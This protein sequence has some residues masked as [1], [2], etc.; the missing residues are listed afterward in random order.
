MNEM[1]EKARTEWFRWLPEQNQPM[2]FYEHS[3]CSPKGKNYQAFCKTKYKG[4][5]LFF[6]VSM[7][8]EGV[9]SSCNVDGIISL[10]PTKIRELYEQMNGRCLACGCL[11]KTPQIIDIVDNLDLLI[12]RKK[13]FYIHAISIFSNRKKQ[14]S[15]FAHAFQ[16]ESAN[17]D[18]HDILLSLRA[19]VR[20][21]IS[22]EEAFVYAAD[23][24]GI[25][26]CLD[27]KPGTIINGFHLSSWLSVQRHYYRR[28]DSQLTR[29]KRNYCTKAG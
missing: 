10:R 29:K 13:S 16:V 11:E 4:L 18:L 17:L 28:Q 8:I 23:Y 25:H 5:K 21:R 6:S 9:H 26:N 14:N 15:A 1:M 24:Y 2:I 19:L 3:Q 12:A 27:V 22:W 7:F 20:N